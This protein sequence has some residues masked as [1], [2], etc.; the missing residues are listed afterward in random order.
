MRWITNDTDVTPN[1]GTTA[2]SSAIRSGGKQTRAAAAAAYQ[3]LLGL[4]ATQLGVAGREPQREQGRRLRWRQDRHLRRSCSAGR[5]STSRWARSTTSPRPRRPTQSAAQ[6][7]AS[8]GSG[9]S[10][11]LAA[12][13]VL[14]TPAFVPSP[15]PGL[16]PGAPDTK[17]VSQYTLVGVAPGPQRVDIPAKVTGVVHL[18]PEHPRSPGCCT[19]AS[20]AR[21]GRAPTATA[22]TPKIAL[23]RHQ[24]DQPH[25]ER[26]R[27][28]RRGTSSASSRRT[29][30]TRSRR[31]RS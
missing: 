20:S 27:S 11:G 22:R 28:C 1:Q 25:P 26:R 18:R 5:C 14:P 10:Q 12:T 3:A 9:S 6:T 29:S 7:V 2:G 23:G 21:A 24:L 4:A 17:P 8:T 15:G 16:S 19:A 13:E 30:T 31:R